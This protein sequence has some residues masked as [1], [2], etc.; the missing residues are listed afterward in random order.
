MGGA[1]DGVTGAFFVFA[2]ADDVIVVVC[3]CVG[4]L[5]ILSALQ[6]V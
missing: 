1:F 2:F 6:G 3:H 4:R 5:C